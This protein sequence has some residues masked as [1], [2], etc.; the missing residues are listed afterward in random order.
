MKHYLKK[1][2]SISAL[3]IVISLIYLRTNDS[4]GFNKTALWAW[5]ISNVDIWIIVITYVLLL[6]LMISVVALLILKL[7]D[8]LRGNTK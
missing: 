6:L 1:F 3:L 5:D 7:R 4:I 8:N 2:I